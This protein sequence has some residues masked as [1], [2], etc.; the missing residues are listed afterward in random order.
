MKGFKL[1]SKKWVK[2]KQNLERD[3]EMQWVHL[4]MVGHLT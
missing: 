2:V 1:L 3:M 4:N